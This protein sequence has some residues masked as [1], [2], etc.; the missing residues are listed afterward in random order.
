MELASFAGRNDLRVDLGRQVYDNLRK[1]SRKSADQ[2]RDLSVLTSDLRRRLSARDELRAELLSETVVASV[3]HDVV[4]LRAVGGPVGPDIR[5]ML[6][7]EALEALAQLGPLYPSRE[8]WTVD[9]REGGEKKARRDRE[10]AVLLASDSARHLM[11]RHIWPTIPDVE[12]FSGDGLEFIRR[13]E[14]TEVPLFVVYDA[15]EPDVMQRAKGDWTVR[16]MHG[17]ALGRPPRRP[18]RKKTR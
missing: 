8:R 13:V 3:D 12:V 17:I 6:R 1:V 18:A 11:G 4:I 5:N 2:W 10:A 14:E 9:V 15:K 16:E 7:K